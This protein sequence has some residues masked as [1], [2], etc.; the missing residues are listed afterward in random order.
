M[1]AKLAVAETLYEDNA[2]NIAA[3]LR[4]AAATIEAE[5]DNTLRTTAMIA[6]QVREDG[7]VEVY[8]WGKTDHFHAIGALTAGIADLTK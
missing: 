7:T 5:D 6:V 1:T 8:G 3:M 4:Q 2:S